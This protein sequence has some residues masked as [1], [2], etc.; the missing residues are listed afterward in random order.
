MEKP[1]QN[2]SPQAVEQI[3]PLTGDAWDRHVVAHPDHTVFHRGAWA[4][5][6]HNSYGHRPH[7]LRFAR[8]GS[9]VALIP[10]MEVRGMVT[11][12]RGVCLPF[13]DYCQPLLSDG[14]D[15]N[16]VRSHLAELAGD[17]GW[18]H[19]EIRGNGEPSRM[20]LAELPETPTYFGH[21]LGLQGEADAQFAGFASSVRRAIRKAERAGL[22]ASV[23]TSWDAVRHFFELHVRTRRR[24]GLPPQPFSFFREVFREV[25]E[26][27]HGFVVVVEAEHG[28]VAAAVFLHSGAHALYKFGASDHRALELRPNNL[29]MWEG[30]KTLIGAGCKTLHFGRSSTGGADLRRFKRAWGGAEFA[31]NYARFQPSERT[32]R[33]VPPD[34][35]GRHEFLFKH[36]PLALN[37]LAGKLIYPQLD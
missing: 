6:L 10:M 1:V 9:T 26:P 11:G 24:H 29:A 18:K 3:D 22:S 21:E 27:G 33:P 35:G 17:M 15:V 30:I 28:P 31:M 36:L 14:C 8:G 2:V 34:S 4:R 7:Y 32:W 23:S 16:F 37:R 25:I 12:R 5:V 13:S 20:E 19:L